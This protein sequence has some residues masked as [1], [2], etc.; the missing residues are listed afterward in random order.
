MCAW[1][2]V[3]RSQNFGSGLCYKTSWYKFI[4]SGLQIRTID[5]GIEIPHTGAFCGMF[6]D[7]QLMCDGAIVFIPR[8]CVV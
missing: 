1:W 5:R 8:S 7:I 4:L 3:S 6:P 2:T